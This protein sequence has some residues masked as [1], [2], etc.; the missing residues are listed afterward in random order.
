[1]TTLANRLGRCAVD[2]VV[3]AEPN[4]IAESLE[5]E[6][7]EGHTVAEPRRVHPAFY[8]CYDWHSAVHSHWL[9]LRLLRTRGALE[10][11]LAG[12]PEA[13]RSTRGPFLFAQTATPRTVRRRRAAQWR[14]AR[15]KQSTS[16]RATG[17]PV[18][19]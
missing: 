2:G 8:G 10:P 1:M 6:Q 9:L 4:V 14:T 7:S 12:Q 3:R 11:A 18:S 16:A 15:W 13:A 17:Q 5:P 19:K